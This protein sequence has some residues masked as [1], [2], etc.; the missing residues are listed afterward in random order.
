MAKKK[1]YPKAPKKTASLEAW[2]KY[3]DKIKDID[4][5]NASIDSDQKKKESVINSVTK[6]KKSRK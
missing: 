3:E 4:K 2:K 5:F 6:R 1:S